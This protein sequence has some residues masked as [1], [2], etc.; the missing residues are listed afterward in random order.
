EV[1]LRMRFRANAENFPDRPRYGN[2]SALAL[3]AWRLQHG[4][5]AVLQDGGEVPKSKVY[6][7]RPDLVGEYRPRPR[8]KGDVSERS[9]VA[10]WNHGAAS[11]RL[12]QRLRRFVG[13]LRI[14]R[15]PAGREPR[16]SL[17]RS[18][19]GQAYVRKRLQ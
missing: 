13:W 15:T 14:E 17:S 8:P 7:S 18:A 5:R 9:S 2:S 16:A 3:P 1:C 19:P 12:R 6:R 10:R 11:F 4:H